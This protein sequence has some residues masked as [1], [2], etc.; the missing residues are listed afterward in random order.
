[1]VGSM[2]A[3]TALEQTALAAILGELTEHRAILEQQLMQAIVLS[4]ENTG[5]G[6]CT[7]LEVGSGAQSLEAEMASLGQDI[8]MGV[9]GLEFGLGIILHIKNGRAYLLEG[10][11]VAPEDTSVIDLTDVRFAVAGEPGSLPANGS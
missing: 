9:E 8:W 11:A 6:F 4:R 3:F 5:G 2:R 10:Y 7:E 1:M